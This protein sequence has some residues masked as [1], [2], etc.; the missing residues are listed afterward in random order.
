MGCI[1]FWGGKCLR[2]TISFTLPQRSLIF[3]RGAK[4]TLILLHASG[5]NNTEAGLY[6]Q[7]L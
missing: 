1:G 2:F 7:S 3:F 5:F 6:F 4:L